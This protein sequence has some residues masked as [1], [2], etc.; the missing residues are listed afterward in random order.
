MRSVPVNGSALFLAVLLF[1]DGC[2]IDDHER[3]AGGIGKHVA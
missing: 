1:P 2:S 3:A